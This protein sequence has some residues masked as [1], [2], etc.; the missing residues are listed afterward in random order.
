MDSV[1]YFSMPNRSG[2]SLPGGVNAFLTPSVG[3]G[4]GATALTVILSLAHSR[5]SVRV[6][7]STPAFAAVAW[8]IKGQPR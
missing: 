6:S 5:A 4:P 7:A 1:A 3:I 2:A 8:A